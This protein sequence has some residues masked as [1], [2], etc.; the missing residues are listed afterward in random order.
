M[1]PKILK[2]CTWAKYKQRQWDFKGH[3]KKDFSF[4]EHPNAGDCHSD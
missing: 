4:Q 2:I 3:N 1:C